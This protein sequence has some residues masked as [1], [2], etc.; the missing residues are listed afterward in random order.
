MQLSPCLLGANRDIHSTQ[1]NSTRSLDAYRQASANAPD[2][3][4]PSAATGGTAGTGEA[5]EP[6]TTTETDGTTES[7]ST[8]GSSSVAISGLAVA[9]GLVA[10][11][12]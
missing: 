2:N 6:G 10:A 11:L 3:V 7:P 1:A 9:V 5:Q 4:S 12:L 8:A